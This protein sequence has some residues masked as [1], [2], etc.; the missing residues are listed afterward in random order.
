MGV[1]VIHELV[2]DRYGVASTKDQ[3]AIQAFAADRVGCQNPILWVPK[4]S[5]T[6]WV[7]KMSSMCPELGSCDTLA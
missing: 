3:H 1:V 7:P 2:E 4:M 5:S 6:V